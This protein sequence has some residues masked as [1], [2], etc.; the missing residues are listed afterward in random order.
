MP[1]VGD[2]PRAALRNRLHGTG[3][4]WA[5]YRCAALRV[6]VR[7]RILENRRLRPDRLDVACWLPQPTVRL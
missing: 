5:V 1:A 2:W 7:G 6:R 3:H 4:Q